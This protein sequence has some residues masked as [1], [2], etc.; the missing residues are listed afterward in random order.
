VHKIPY[1][2]ILRLTTVEFT[3]VEKLS[4]SIG[5]QLVKKSTNYGWIMTIGQ[6]SCLRLM[7]KT[8]F[9]LLKII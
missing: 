1:V 7:W 9:K 6:F 2:F 5:I 3:S 4:Q 8:F